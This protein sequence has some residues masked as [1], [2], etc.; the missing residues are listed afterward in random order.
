MCIRDRLKAG[1]PPYI[2]RRLSEGSVHL[3]A[4]NKRGT[5]EGVLQ[6]LSEHFSLSLLYRPELS[7][8][9]SVSDLPS[10]GSRGNKKV[11]YISSIFLEAS[12]MMYAHR[13]D[14]DEDD[15]DEPNERGEY[16]DHDQPRIGAP[17]SATPLS[18]P[19]AAYNRQQQHLLSPVNQHASSLG[20]SNVSLFQTPQRLP[21]GTSLMNRS[22]TLGG[23]NNNSIHSMATSRVEP[24]ASMN[25]QSN[26]SHVEEWPDSR[27]RTPL[28]ARRVRS[29]GTPI[30][31]GFGEDTRSNNSM[32]ASSGGLVKTPSKQVGLRRPSPSRMA[33]PIAA[34]TVDVLEMIS[35][36]YR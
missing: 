26:T 28:H 11:K 6:G 21:S 7:S 1:C 27:D 33:N 29:F 18:L 12:S 13:E 4:R 15:D 30:Q 35:E 22:L 19:I 36:S 8:A 23:G 9:L 3:M 20:S 34:R 17:P 14:V 25:N 5:L 16:D 31:N 10:G 32:H 2:T 24:T